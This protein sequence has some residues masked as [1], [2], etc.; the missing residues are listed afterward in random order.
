MSAL[1]RIKPIDLAGLKPIDVGDA[2]PELT[3][4]APTDLMVDA[5]YQRELSN[6]SIK[7]IRK[8][9]E[10]FAWN[11]L[12]P[13][14]VVKTGPASLHVI[15]GQHT[16][17][18]AATLQ[19]PKIPILIVSA[20]SVDERARA[21]VGHNMDRV[22]VSPFD[23]F[24]A[25]LAAGDPDAL[26]VA[27][28]CRRANVRVRKISPQSLVAEGDTAAVGIIRNLVKR[29]GVMKARMILQA[30]SMAKR[31]PIAAAE[32]LAA[33]AI[34]MRPAAPSVETL[35]AVVRIDGIAGLNAAHAKAKTD[36]IPIYRALIA[37][38]ERRLAT[39][40]A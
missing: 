21:F 38:W 5:T 23:I 3:W 29:R 33:E 2:L 13:P 12:K 37:R 24:N 20:E 39:V 30:L 40:G 18:V 17:I 36:K 8:L 27:N 1:R 7:L 34:L 9:V 25:L 11:R 26:D 22:S 19:I 16:A 14:I 35:A 28:V 4:A 10:T 31:A 6:W 15:D 32:I